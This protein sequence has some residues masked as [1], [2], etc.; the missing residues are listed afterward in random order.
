MTSYQAAVGPSG[1]KVHIFHVKPG[2]RFAGS[3]SLCRCVAAA[4]AVKGGVGIELLCKKCCEVLSGPYIVNPVDFSCE[5]RTIT[6]ELIGIREI[7]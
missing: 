1:S 2:I 4:R 5:P 7:L 6:P 3:L